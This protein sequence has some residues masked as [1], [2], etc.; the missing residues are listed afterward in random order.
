MFGFIKKIFK[1]KITMISNDICEFRVN[2]NHSL[3]KRMMIVKIV[4]SLRGYDYDDDWLKNQLN[5]LDIQYDQMTFS[6]VCSK[7][8]FSRNLKI[9]FNDESFCYSFISKEEEKFITKAYDKKNILPKEK[10]LFQLERSNQSFFSS[11]I[12]VNSGM[13]A[14]NKVFF[15]LKTGLGDFDSIQNIVQQLVTLMSTIN[16]DLF[17]FEFARL[18]ESE[19]TFDK[20][21]QLRPN[22]CFVDD[23]REIQK[24]LYMAKMKEMDP[25]IMFAPL[26][27]HKGLCAY[28]IFCAILTDIAYNSSEFGEPLRNVKNTLQSQFQNACLYKIEFSRTPVSHDR[29]DQRG[30]SDH[31]SVMKLYLVDFKHKNVFV[32]LDL[33]HES[34]TSPDRKIQLHL[35]YES[36]SKDYQN[37]VLINTSLRDASL[38]GVIEEIRD[39][40][41]KCIPHMVDIIDS[42]EPDEKAVK[43]EMNWLEL[44]KRLS[45]KHITGEDDSKEIGVLSKN[46]NVDENFE[47]VFQKCKSKFHF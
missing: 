35:N 32:R 30:P 17:Q 28:T 15:Q 9:V 31:T 18:D 43:Q 37:H 34:R 46:F 21:I 11:Y 2:E 40:V 33:P 4:E 42:S 7:M 38:N 13:L 10:N 22:N 41:K 39:Y 20:C 8:R 16:T 6:N 29:V 14:A 3:Y 45:Y 5:S 47:S 27:W 25:E 1:K 24:F 23:N 36:T 26:L 44:F 19:R 12:F